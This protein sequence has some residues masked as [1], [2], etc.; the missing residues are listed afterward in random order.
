MKINTS[1]VANTTRWITT[2][3]LCAAVIKFYVQKVDLNTSILSASELATVCQRIQGCKKIEVGTT[4][5]RTLGHGVIEI[6]VSANRRSRSGAFEATLDDA[7]SK[8]WKSNANV[9]SP[10]WRSHQLKVSYD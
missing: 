4:L 7:V 3:A 1:R 2:I 8:A 10:P 9:F 5:E 6:R